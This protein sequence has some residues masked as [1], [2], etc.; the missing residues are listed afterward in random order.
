[1]EVYELLLPFARDL[2]LLP[3]VLA[4]PSVPSPVRMYASVVARAPG[5]STP[6]PPVTS[7]VELDLARADLARARAEAESL[8]RRSRF[9]QAA[10]VLAAVAGPA[11]RV[12][13]PTDP[14]VLSLRFELAGTWFDG[15]DYRRAGPAYRDLA[16][17]FVARFGPDDDRAMRC[18]RQHATCAA[19]T[20]D[21]ATALRSLRA[22]ADEE[23]RLHGPDDDRV[24]E[25]RKQIAL[26]DLGAGR[27]DLARA[28]LCAL[29]ADVERLRGPDDPIAAGV[30][31]ILR[32]AFHD[33]A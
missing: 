14:A 15:G 25:L 6:A 9:S 31:D 11:T 13:G 16:A 5:G 21:I 7:G 17:D 27:H 4:A 3:G 32:D 1:V 23:R 18:R 33:E 24:L 29:L 19:L 2:E 8:V 26:L 12:F 20:G 22:L 30:R 10:D 28:D